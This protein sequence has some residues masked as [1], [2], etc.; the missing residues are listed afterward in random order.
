MGRRHS[1][2]R[3][4]GASPRL[5]R[6]KLR[7]LRALCRVAVRRALVLA[8]LVVVAPGCFGPAV[9]GST[10]GRRSLSGLVRLGMAWRVPV[11]VATRRRFGG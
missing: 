9:G 4:V 11:I 1:V 6:R 2:N 5:F 7:P 10:L 8:V 3:A